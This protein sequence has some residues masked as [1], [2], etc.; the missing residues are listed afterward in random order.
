MLCPRCGKKMGVANTAGAESNR[1]YLLDR[2]AP[3]IEWYSNEFVARDRRCYPCREAVLTIELD[4][5]DLIGALRYAQIDGPM[6]TQSIIDWSHHI[7][8]NAKTFRENW[9]PT[10]PEPE[11]TSSDDEGP[12]GERG[13]RG[14][15]RA[16]GERDGDQ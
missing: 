4:I 14:G 6:L 11:K 13:S 9:T 3:F 5:E 7:R 16:R 15:S 2:I 1:V 8:E 12:R 10:R